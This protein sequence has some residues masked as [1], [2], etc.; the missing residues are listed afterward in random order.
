MKTGWLTRAGAFRVEHVPYPYLGS[1]V[2]TYAPAK[3]LLH[4]TQGSSIEGALSVFRVHYAPNF[5]VGAD[6]KK[7]VRI[8]QHAP[9]GVM[10]HALANKAGGVETN[11]VVRAQIEI[12][13]FS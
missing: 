10:G 5:T 11:R 7:K 6:A 9:L 4:T 3:G 12:V 8:L 2:N 1:P 13:G